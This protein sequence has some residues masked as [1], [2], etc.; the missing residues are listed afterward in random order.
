MYTVQRFADDSRTEEGSEFVWGYER[1]DLATGQAEARDFGPL[2]VV[3]FSGMTRPGHRNEFFGALTQLKKYDV[4]KQQVLKTI[5]LEHSYYCVNFS[6]D[7]E[8]LYLAG[9]YNDIAIYDPDT[10]EK[11]GNIPLPG[12]DMSLATAQVFHRNP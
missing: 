6:T 12:G 4:E 5:D 9:T 11:L 8:E 7:G 2:E 1:V 10:L 3:L